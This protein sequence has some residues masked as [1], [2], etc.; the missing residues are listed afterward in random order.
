LPA[1]FFVILLNYKF[2]G[3]GGES[4]IIIIARAVRP[5]ILPA[6][7]MIQLLDFRVKRKMKYLS[8]KPAGTRS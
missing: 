2:P 8:G 5:G 1:S 6:V 7:T 3:F 4:V